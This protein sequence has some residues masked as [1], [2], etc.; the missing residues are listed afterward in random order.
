MQQRRGSLATETE[1]QRGREGSHKTR[2]FL[3]LSY[4]HLARDFSKLVLVAFKPLQ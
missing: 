1:R 4:M 2:K 3:I